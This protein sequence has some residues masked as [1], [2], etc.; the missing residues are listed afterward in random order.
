MATDE[1][2]MTFDIVWTRQG[3]SVQLLIGTYCERPEKP[4]GRVSVLPRSNLS[5]VIQKPIKNKRGVRKQRH[6]CKKWTAKLRGLWGDRSIYSCAEAT[7]WYCVDLSCF[8]LV[9]LQSIKSI[10]WSQP[11]SM[12]DLFNVLRIRR[13]FFVSPIPNNTIQ[14]RGIKSNKVTAVVFSSTTWAN[15]L[16]S[17]ITST[18]GYTPW[19]LRGPIIERWS[20][21]IVIKERKWENK[22]HRFRGAIPWW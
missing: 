6:N 18:S 1:L 15:F 7:K 12:V 14:S 11:I 10:I 5:F 4:L 3:Y 13:H 2:L 16:S 22:E 9:H 8:M 21:R 20:F 17:V 19:P